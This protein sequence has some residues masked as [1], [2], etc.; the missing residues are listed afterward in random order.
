MAFKI[1]LQEFN[2][3]KV[4]KG[5]NSYE[6]GVATY[7][8]NGVNKNQTIMSFAN[9]A[10]FAA[11]KNAAQGSVFLVET[12][13][14]DAGYDTWSKVTP[15]GAD[16]PQKATLFGGVHELTGKPV[17]TTNNTP[18]RTTYET[19]EERKQKQL[20]IIRQ[21]SISNAIETLSVGAKSV[22]SDKVLELAQKYVDFVY[23]L[24]QLA[25]G[26]IAP[27]DNPAAGA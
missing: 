9:P 8:F 10:V 20:Y 17:N 21:S 5:R 22:D 7:T 26:K 25:A 12:T 6:K 24:P 23:D 11:L 19:P 27:E 16:T 3:E 14:N 2:V 13:K 15:E 18:V 4:Q 1:T